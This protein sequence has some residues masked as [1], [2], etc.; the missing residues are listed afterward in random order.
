[1]EDFK[2]NIVDLLKTGVKTKQLTNEKCSVCC[3]GT[4]IV[5]NEKTKLVCSCNCILKQS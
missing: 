2:Q 4:V 1:M 3:T 5:D